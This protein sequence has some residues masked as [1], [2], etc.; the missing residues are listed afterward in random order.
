M[1]RSKNQ[2]NLILWRFRVQFPA[3]FLENQNEPFSVQQM[4]TLLQSRGHQDD[5]FT[6]WGLL[7]EAPARW[8]C[9][10][11][12]ICLLSSKSRE[13]FTAWPTQR[14]FP[15]RQT[16]KTHRDDHESQ[17]TSWP[18]SSVSTTEFPS[19]TVCESERLMS[20]SNLTASFSNRLSVQ[21]CRTSCVQQADAFCGPAV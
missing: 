17:K 20:E 21:R 8:T 16:L 15:V 9:L 5:S 3:Q 10:F 4:K 7:K 14:P 2:L 11:E 6:Q 18:E 1:I 12:L 13:N 19:L